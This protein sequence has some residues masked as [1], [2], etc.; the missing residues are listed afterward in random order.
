MTLVLTSGVGTLAPKARE[1][2]IKVLRVNMKGKLNT[3]R[4]AWGKRFLREQKPDI[5]HTH[6]LDNHFMV[7]T[8]AIL[9]RIPL[10]ITHHHTM[11]GPRY[12]PNMVEV[13]RRLLPATDCSIFVGQGASDQLW[14][15]VRDYVKPEEKE[16]F[17]VMFDALDIKLIR[18]QGDISHVQK[19]REEF[20][21]RPDQPVIGAVA[22]LHPVKNL[23][24]LVRVVKTL[25]ADFPSLRC[26]V[27]GEGDKAYLEKIIT[28]AREHGVAE[29]FIFTGYREDAAAFLGMFNVTVL[30]SNT[31]GLPR[32]IIESY[33]LGTP[34]VSTRVGS[35]PEILT[36]GQEGY[37]TE[38][39][40]EEELV[41]KIGLIL[42][43]SEKRGELGEHAVKRS[44][45]FDLGPFVERICGLYDNLL[46]SPPSSPRKAKSRYRLRYFFTHRP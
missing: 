38:P 5:V 20:S 12:K 23:E 21:V 44:E 17:K 18:E 31:E 25:T 34:V 6:N 46:S 27:V 11:P 15:M 35:I 19:L 7:R 13:E 22:R 41:E 45:I 14:D 16:R 3:K 33:A 39:G 2:G 29:N 28:M 4:I 32:S 24:L 30:T 26:F 9:A 42:S 1:R 8:A 10:V 43:S 40:S 37:L 36:D